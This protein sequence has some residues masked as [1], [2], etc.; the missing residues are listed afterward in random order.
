MRRQWHRPRALSSLG[1]S[2]ASFSGLLLRELTDH[3]GL[4][5]LPRDERRR[6][7][8]VAS[9]DDGYCAVVSYGELYLTEVGNRMFVATA[10]DGTALDECDGPFALVSRADLRTGPRHAR[11]H[12]SID[13]VRIQPMNYEAPRRTL[14]NC[15]ERLQPKIA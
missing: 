15:F 1:R 8:I 7:V 5:G 14:S 2:A 11:R 3:A 12:R 6:S 13:V 4:P 9:A 10:L